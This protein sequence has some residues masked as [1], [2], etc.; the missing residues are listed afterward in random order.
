MDGKVLNLPKEIMIELSDGSKK[1]VPYTDITSI[2]KKEI[3]QSYT[4]FLNKNKDAK[5]SPLEKEAAD[6]FAELDTDKGPYGTPSLTFETWRKAAM[7][8]DIDGMVN[9]YAEY[10]KNDIKKGL[11]KLNKKTREDM[12]T[13]MIETIFT[14]NQP[15][16]Q[17]DSAIMEV[18]WSKG[19]ASQTQTL[20]FKLE[21]NKDWKIV[22]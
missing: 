3:P 21:K 12:K 7:A 6:S 19:L 16:Y 9:C 17:G 14:P 10:R 13:A 5:K 4:P 20:K 1:T 15:Y 2:Y 22:E 8:D 18:S 11:K